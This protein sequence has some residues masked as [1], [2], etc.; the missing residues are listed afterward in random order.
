MV[1]KTQSKGHGVTGLNV[2]SNNVRRYF[3]QG[4]PFVEL[5]LEQVE[6]QCGLT[7]EFWQ[8]RPEIHDPRLCAWLDSKHLNS[9][10]RSPV[11]LAMIP[12][13]KNAFKLRVT[14]A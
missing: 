1:V 11:A 8:D 6:I 14:A 7:A 12:A 13:G 2:G 4:I 9:A 5:Q 3:T 10:G